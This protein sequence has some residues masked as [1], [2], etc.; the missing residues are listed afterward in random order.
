MLYH[1]DECKLEKNVRDHK[2]VI[3]NVRQH[4]GTVSI[5]REDLL[6]EELP[7]N[8]VDFAGIVSTR[9]AATPKSRSR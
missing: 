5:C 1:E 8:E 3:E 4:R 2:E 6:H 9:G 7:V